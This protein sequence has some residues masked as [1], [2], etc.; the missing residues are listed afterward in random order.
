MYWLITLGPLGSLRSGALLGQTSSGKW[1]THQLP[2]HSLHLNAEVTKNSYGRARLTIKDHCLPLPQE[3]RHSTLR[4]GRLDCIWQACHSWHSPAII[5]SSWDRLRAWSHKSR[6]PAHA[7]CGAYHSWI[8][9]NIALPHKSRPISRKK[10]KAGVLLGSTEV[11]YWLRNLDPW[12]A[13]RA[14]SLRAPRV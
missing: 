13:K 11:D 6:A 12:R 14:A 8:G 4:D 2:M 5:I 7:N 9:S 10:A 3:I 1:C